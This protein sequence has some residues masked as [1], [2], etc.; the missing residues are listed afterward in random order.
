MTRSIILDAVNHAGTYAL[1]VNNQTF[2]KVQ[3]ITVAQLLKGER[4]TMPQ[5]LLPYIAALS[6]QQTQGLF[7]RV[8]TPRERRPGHSRDVAFN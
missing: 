6:A 1:P 8:T 3:I 5:T 2:P 4:P 7:W